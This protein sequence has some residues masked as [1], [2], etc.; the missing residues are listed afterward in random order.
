[1]HN[2]GGGRLCYRSFSYLLDLRDFDL[3]LGSGHTAYCREALPTY[4]P[5]GGH[6]Y[7]RTDTETV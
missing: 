6:T 3:D 1:M 7:R 4:L 2:G 5:N